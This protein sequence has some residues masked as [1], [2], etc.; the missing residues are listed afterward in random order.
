MDIGSWSNVTN[1]PVFAVH[2]ALIYNPAA[3][4]WKVILF[5]G[6]AEADTPPTG[7]NDLRKSYLWNPDTNTFSSQTFTF[8]AANDLSDPFCAHQCQLADGRL[9]VM[10]GSFYGGPDGRG[11]PATWVFDPIPETWSR[12]GDMAFYRWYP[13]SV[14]L[15]D[16]RVLVASGRTTALPVPQM[17]VFDPNTDTWTTLPSSADKS[18]DSYPS[19][20][21]V[22]SGPNAG[23]VFYT[24]TRWAGSSGRNPWTAPQTALFDPVANSWQNVSSHNNS[25]RTEGFSLLLPPA[26]CGRFLVFGGGQ[27]A[28]DADPNSAEVI[29]LMQSNPQW[30][31]VQ[32]M[33]NDRSNVTGVILPN[34]TVFVFGGHT[35]YK[36]TASG[37]AAGDK[38]VYICEIYD[39]KTGGWME[40]APMAQPRQ[41]HSVGVL[42]PD[43]RVLCAGGIFPGTGDRLNMEIFSPPYM[44][45][46]NRPVISAVSQR[47]F[48]GNT[49]QVDTPQSADIDQVILIRPMAITHHTDSEQRLVRLSFN[50]IN[51]GTLEVTAPG[52]PNLA[53]PGYYMLFLI[54]ACGTPSVAKFIHMGFTVTKRKETKEKEF[55]EIKEFKEKEFKEFKEIKEFKEKEIKEF[56][57]KKETKEKEL[58]EIK[59]KDIFEGGKLETPF[60]HFIQ[61]ELRPDLMQATLAREP[62]IRPPQPPKL[63]LKSPKAEVSR[64]TVKK[65][66]SK[67]RAKKKKKG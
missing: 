22:P 53:P 39:P 9:L 4:K 33:H 8:V 19:L 18:L 35:A 54:N 38:H 25:N 59:E 16:G 63:D 47:F 32:D 62:N 12:V 41:Y 11:I 21:L 23:K 6:G 49:F 48:Y 15:P 65:A 26:E 52:N 27:D 30:V 10:G 60:T 13:T 36:G 51:A 67:G 55:K 50:L 57:E 40:T 17:E 44:N 24:G 56:K 5:S 29:D 42:L 3:D 43:G 45:E 14:K 58:K 66:K 37:T 1:I 46:P 64:P 2:G 28:S 20:H 7:T 34:S 31:N 61:P